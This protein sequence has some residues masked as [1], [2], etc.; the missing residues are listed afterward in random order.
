MRAKWS[1]LRLGS[2][3]ALVALVGAILG[4]Q[5]GGSAGFDLGGYDWQRDGIPV[6]VDESAAT[7]SIIVVP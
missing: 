1:S 2:G 6:V 4:T 7:Q 3:L 5:L